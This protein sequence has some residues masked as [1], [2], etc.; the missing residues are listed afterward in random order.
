MTKP[1]EFWIN[2]INFEQIWPIDDMAMTCFITFNNPD[3]KEAILVR[4]VVP[5]DWEK[6]WKGF[7]EYCAS[8]RC[9]HLWPQSE[10]EIQQ[11]IEKQLRGEK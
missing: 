5:I 6:V 1:R 3:R 4:E 2:G 7:E 10:K 8:D 9:T 11:L